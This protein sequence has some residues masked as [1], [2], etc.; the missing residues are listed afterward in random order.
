[1][2]NSS[3][4]GVRRTKPACDPRRFAVPSNA[5]PASRLLALWLTGEWSCPRCGGPDTDMAA[6]L[7]DE[8]T[9]NPKKE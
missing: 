4:D 2:K 7:Y 6:R 3:E 9:Q 8:Y 1:M 5:C